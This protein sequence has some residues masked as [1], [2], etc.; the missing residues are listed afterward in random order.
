MITLSAPKVQFSRAIR[1]MLASVDFD[2][3][4]IE[5]VYV[6]GGIGSGI[7]MENAVR[8]GMFPDIPIE[9]FTYMVTLHCQAP[10]RCCFPQ[11]R[12]TYELAANMTYLELSTVPTYM[13]EFVACCFLPHTDST[14]F[15]SFY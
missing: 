7:N 2:I 15:P 6:A 1:T 10:I 13:D 14:L 12:K 5:Q 3:S 9:K 8:I 11:Q 4:M